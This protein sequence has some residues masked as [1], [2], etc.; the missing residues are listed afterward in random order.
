MEDDVQMHHTAIQLR[1]MM[2]QARF[3]DVVG[4]IMA[5]METAAKDGRRSLLVGQ[6]NDYGLD[7][8]RQWLGNGDSTTRVG[9]C[10]KEFERLGYSVHF[11]TR[12]PVGFTIYW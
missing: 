6:K 1:Q 8:V 12:D 4:R 7:D 3:L 10:I 11:D 2:P 9:R 5:D